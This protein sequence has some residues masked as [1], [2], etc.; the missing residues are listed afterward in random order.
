MARHNFSFGFEETEYNRS[1]YTQN[2]FQ[3]MNMTDY[4]YKDLAA[5]QHINFESALEPRHHP[6]AFIL[7]SMGIV[8]VVFNVLTLFIVGLG[9]YTSKEIKVQIMN[10]AVAD[11][12]MA[13]FDPL[14][15]AS[16]MYLYIPFSDNKRIC[17]VYMFM[18]SVAHYGSLICKVAIC[19]E[20]FVII[21]FP[22]RASHYSRKHKFVVIAC[23]WTYT[24][25][26]AIWYAVG[27]DIADFGNIV[28]CITYNRNIPIEIWSWL[29]TAQYLLPAGIIVVVYALVFIKICVNKTSGIKRHL[30]YQWRK[31]L[32]KVRELIKHLISK[33]YHVSY[34]IFL[35]LSSF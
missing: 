27:A 22:F 30:S 25:L 11:L 19:L 20:R 35:F 8:G 12:L 33:S 26:S 17:Q 14:A 6:N 5:D 34:I 3:Q 24:S 18:K 10:L 2:E 21:F 32:D 28:Q 9:K 15:H 13:L 31:E 1:S 29:I 16:S 4:N 23:V 7:L